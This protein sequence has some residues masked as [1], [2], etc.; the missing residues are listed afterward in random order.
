MGDEPRILFVDDEDS[1]RLTL[2]PVLQSYGFAVTSVA[3]VAEALA[4]VTRYKC[5]VLI[6][7]LSIARPGAGYTVATAMS[8][9]QPQTLRSILTAYPP[10][11]SALDATRQ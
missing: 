11:Q 6:S 5:D 1:I 10:L 7:H 2:P 8:T 9:H 3:T 4:G